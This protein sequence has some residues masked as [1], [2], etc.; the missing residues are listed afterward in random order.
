[1][2]PEVMTSATTS[3]HVPEWAA[4]AAAAAEAAEEGDVVMGMGQDLAEWTDWGW[5]E[6]LLAVTLTAVF[7]CT[8][9][10]LVTDEDEPIVPMRSRTWTKLGVLVVHGLAGFGLLARHVSV[11]DAWLGIACLATSVCLGVYMVLRIAGCATRGLRH[12]AT[13]GPNGPNGPNGL[14]GPHVQQLYV[15]SWARKRTVSQSESSYFGV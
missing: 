4:A 15:P 13:A 2:A 1:M 6:V 14:K 11:L 3:P 5:R 9:V 8:A 10:W 7:V 12:A